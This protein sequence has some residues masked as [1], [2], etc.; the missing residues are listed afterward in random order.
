[1]HACEGDQCRGKMVTERALTVS[2]TKKF[3]REHGAG[4]YGKRFR[5]QQQGQIRRKARVRALHEILGRVQRFKSAGGRQGRRMG[6]RYGSDLCY[7]ICCFVDIRQTGLQ[8]TR[9]NL[10]FSDLT[11]LGE[12]K[13]NINSNCCSTIGLLLVKLNLC[14]RR[15]I[16]RR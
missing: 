12:F 6:V 15:T 1:M 13:I 16:T 8:T 14:R 10:P 3:A 7:H 2:A 5:D 9:V 11:A 4:N